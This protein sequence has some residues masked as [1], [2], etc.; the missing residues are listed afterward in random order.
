MRRSTSLASGSRCAIHLVYVPPVRNCQAADRAADSLSPLALEMWLAESARR[1]L[2]SILP[3]TMAV[4]VGA[5]EP[6]YDLVPGPAP[7]LR[8][9][10]TAQVSLSLVPR[11]GERLLAD[12]PILVRVRGQGVRPLQTLY[13]REDAADPPAD[14]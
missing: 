11:S 6:A 2:V 5:A 7:K 8:A 10:Q 1:A 4:V 14:V 3:W 9:N 12:G 13:R